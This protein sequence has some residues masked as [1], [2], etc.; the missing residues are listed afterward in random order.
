MDAPD[1]YGPTAKD[2]I[3][4]IYSLVNYV[5]SGILINTIRESTTM[6]DNNPFLSGIK[7]YVR[8]AVWIDIPSRDV[9]IAVL[10]QE[11]YG[12]TYHHIL[13]YERSTNDTITIVDCSDEEYRT[14]V[15][16]LNSLLKWYSKNLPNIRATRMQV[17]ADI[18]E[19]IS[20]E[21]RKELIEHLISSYAKQEKK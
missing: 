8:A 18:L 21:D 1:T 5:Q 7:D 13:Y 12:Y 9:T 11:K 6:I 19:S 15:K 17:L 14:V 16:I 10:E 4:W 20:D 3:E 2:V